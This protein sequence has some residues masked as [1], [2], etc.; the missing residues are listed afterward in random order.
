[1]P[2]KPAL[3]ARNHQFTALHRIYYKPDRPSDADVFALLMEMGT[4]KSK[5]VVD[6]WGERA[7]YEEMSDLL[8]IAP[9]GC[10]RNWDRDAADDDLAEVHKHIDPQMWDK[11]RIAPWRSGGGKQAKEAVKYLI[12]TRGRPRVFVVNCEALSS[13]E[14]A[15]VACEEFIDSSERGVMMAIDES[16]VI[17]NGKSNR[18]QEIEAL[19]RRPRVIA[20][21][22]LTGLVAPNS[23]MNIWSQYNFLDPRIVGFRS[24]VNFKLRYAITEELAIGGITDKMAREQGIAHRPNPR[25]I[26]AYKNIDELHEKI[27]PYSYRVLKDE[28]LDLPPKVYLPIR[29][30]TM[31]AEQRRI[32]YEM[33]EFA[34]AQLAAES[35]VTATMVLTHRL[36][37]SQI[38]NGYTKDDETGEIRE[39]PENRTK[40]L[41]EMIEETQGKVIIW[42][43]HEYSVH[44]ISKALMEQYGPRSVA[45]FWGGN[46]STRHLDEARFKTDPMCRFNV[47]TPSAGGRGNTWI[48]A[49]LSVFYDNS[50]NLEHR[51]QAED[52]NHREGL[53]GPKGAGTASYGD[54]A[55]EGTLDYKKI[56]N[57]R[58]K[59]DL[60]AMITADPRKNWIV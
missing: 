50:D 37:L 1:M 52:R 43:H 56:R 15:I 34:T 24:F 49:G 30:V 44:K 28:C 22:I 6:E 3:P 60:A 7:Y 2:Y 42:T 41:L 10:Y 55:A 23:P 19:G 16:T 51:M 48:V 25:P 46:R 53:V 17:A 47:A 35:Y 58:K 4:G 54:I 31:A 32:Y 13:V 14:R 5:V 27:M 36:R 45:R 8:I 18:S 11:V 26:V 39:F 33:Q 21:R 40:V 9:A 59:I 12:Q 29:A 38:L 20:R 57:L